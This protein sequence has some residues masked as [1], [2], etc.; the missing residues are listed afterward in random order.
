MFPPR[1]WPALLFMRKAAWDEDMCRKLGI[2]H[3]ISSP[4][5]CACDHVVGTVTEKAAE[6]ALL[7]EHRLLP[8]V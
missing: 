8:V 3:G 6:A 1:L 2:P 5:I 7:W 4:E